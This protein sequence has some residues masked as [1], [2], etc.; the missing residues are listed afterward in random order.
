MPA[1]Q[2]SFI[3]KSTTRPRASSRMTL[4]SWPPMST[5]VRQAGSSACAPR[6]W[7]VISVTFLP[8][9]AMLARPYPVPTVPRSASGSTPAAS[10]TRRVTSSAA[11]G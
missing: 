10:S 7:Q 2:R 3:A 8:A 11:R 9:R 1:A 5:T 4:L 6:A